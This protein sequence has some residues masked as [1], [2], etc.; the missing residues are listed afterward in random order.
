[1]ED[2][3]MVERDYLDHLM[4]CVKSPFVMSTKI[5]ESCF[6]DFGGVI[7]PYVVLG[8]FNYTNGYDTAR[9]IV[10]SI[11]VENHISEADNAK[12]L[13]WE[14]EY[15]FSLPLQWVPLGSARLLQILETK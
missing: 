3:Y 7:H 5:Q 15:D 9:G 13:A 11:L 10:I 8:D 2:D 1:M 14:T 6:A 12:A 4:Q